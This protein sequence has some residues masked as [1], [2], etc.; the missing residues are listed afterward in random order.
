MT[1][2]R[3][4]RQDVLRR[5]VPLIRVASAT[6]RFPPFPCLGWFAVDDAIGTL[7][8]CQSFGNCDSSPSDKL[9]KKLEAHRKLLPSCLDSIARR[10]C[11]SCND[12]PLAAMASIEPRCRCNDRP[13][14]PCLSSDNFMI[15]R[16]A[17]TRFSCEMSNNCGGLTRNPISRAPEGTESSLCSTVLPSQ[18]QVF[19]KCN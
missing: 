1:V 19:T 2:N 3:K 15:R 16:L 6:T 13:G 7:D 18:A 4:A 17:V 11:R 10:I 9:V 8:I 5:E 14:F 12:S